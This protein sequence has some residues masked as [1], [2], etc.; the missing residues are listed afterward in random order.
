MLHTLVDWNEDN[1][2]ERGHFIFA[3]IVNNRHYANHLSVK[4]RYVPVIPF[5]VF[6]FK[7]YGLLTLQVVDAD[8]NIRGDA[9][10]ELNKRR[11]NYDGKS[12]TYSVDNR[13]ERRDHLLTVQLNEFTAVFDVSKRLVQPYSGGY[14]DGKYSPD[15][16]SYMI[17]DKNK[18]KPGETVR[19]KSYS[20]S[21]D[22]YPIEEELSVW[23]MPG[24]SL[25]KQVGSVSPHHPGGFAGEFVLHDSLKMKLDKRYPLQLRDSTGRIVASTNFYYEEYELYSNRLQ[26]HLHNRSHYYPN[27][28]RLEISATDANGLLLQGMQ[29]DVTVKRRHVLNAYADLLLLPDTLL[30]RRIE[31]DPAAPTLFD[32]PHDL[33]GESDCSYDVEVLLLSFDNQRMVWRDMVTFYRSHYNITC[34]T[35]GDSIYFRFYELG[36]ERTVTAEL[37]YN[38]GEDPKTVQLPYSEKFNQKTVAY[39]IRTLQPEYQRSFATN[40]IGNSFSL[41]GGFSANAFSVKFLNPL[42]L[43]VSWYV[44]RGNVLLQK[45][46]SKE[47]DFKKTER[48]W[49]TT[50]YVE[51]FYLMGDRELAYR[52]VFAPQADYLSVNVDLPEK[53]YPGQTVDASILVT[54]HLGNP[55]SKVD[56]TAFGYNS[57]LNYYVPDLPYYGAPPITRE[58]RASYSMRKREYIHSS[59]FD[60]FVD[61]ATWR[62]LVYMSCRH[63]LRCI[64]TSVRQ[65]DFF[66]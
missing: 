26:V 49:T 40:A 55:V 10:V 1:K 56:L 44:Y 39:N 4:Y 3:E 27:A 51:I 13:S 43:D 12:R 60:F 16:Y 66:G 38:N 34:D 50:Y 52:R 46:S 41:E 14:S 6:L 22:K 48:E 20:L 32:I 54:N 65:K 36:R 24:N 8:G 30:H 37:T 28:N 9:K 53:V 21:R 35:Q 11:I 18:Y 15:F 29:A 2:P 42:Q 61:A 59:A 64:I 5:Q 45:G 23:T 17:T 63:A 62:L 31:L 25:Y 47:F 58:Q 57:L 7:E 33:F 19:F